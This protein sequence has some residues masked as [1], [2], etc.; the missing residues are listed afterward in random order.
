M[1]E[2]TNGQLE[3]KHEIVKWYEHEL[4]PDYVYAGPA[5][6]GKT[7]ILTFIVKELGLEPEEVLY[8]AFTGKAASVL[9]QKGFDASTIHSSSNFSLS[10]QFL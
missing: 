10:F 5:G 7:S 3:L 2:L 6:T 8:C 9:M 1:F 4:G